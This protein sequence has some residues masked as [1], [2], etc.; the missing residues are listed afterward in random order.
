MI[1]LRI[2]PARLTRLFEE[3][4]ENWRDKVIKWWNTM[5]DLDH[6]ECGTLKT[7][8]VHKKFTLFLY[9][10]AGSGKTKFIE[11][12]LKCFLKQKQLFKISPKTKLDKF[13][14][15]SFDMEVH[16]VT[17]IDEFVEK[18]ADLSSL[19]TFCAGEMMLGEKKNRQAFEFRNDFPV[20]ISS[21]FI[22]PS[23][24]A[25]NN[26]FGE[27]L[28]I[29]CCNSNGTHQKVRPF[30]YGDSTETRHLTNVFH[31]GQHQEPE[32][33]EYAEY[34]ALKDE[35]I[36]KGLNP[37]SSFCPIRLL[38]LEE[39]DKVIQRPQSS[40]QR[41]PDAVSTF[42][43]SISSSKQLT[44]DSMEKFKYPQNTKIVSTPTISERRS[45][46]CSTMQDDCVI[47]SDDDDNDKIKKNNTSNL[48]NN[49]IPKIKLE[50]TNAASQ[51]V[52]SSQLSTRNL[53]IDTPITPEFNLT[54]FL[55][56]T[57]L[58]RL[59]QRKLTTSNTE[60]SFG[61]ISGNTSR[62]ISLIASLPLFT[63]NGMAMRR[64]P[65]KTKAAAIT[66]EI[67]ITDDETDMTQQANK[68][69]LVTLTPNGRTRDVSF[70]FS[71]ADLE[72]FNNILNDDSDIDDDLNNVF[73]K[74]SATQKVNPFPTPVTATTSKKIS[75]SKSPILIETSTAIKR[76]IGVR[77]SSPNSTPVVASRKDT[78]SP[79]SNKNS[80]ISD[81]LTKPEEGGPTQ[82][83][84]DILEYK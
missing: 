8:P 54:N 15:G 19:K 39:R 76:P 43:K 57:I 79:C 1:K 11:L 9:G 41:V 50:T 18:D 24:N 23:D 52:Q 7:K 51:Q 73:D 37:E 63:E 26:T 77:Y 42:S 29:V 25:F 62:L 3:Q 69:S 45:S 75:D 70:K 58:E 67:M 4:Q 16:R 35:A 81:T 30:Q 13:A 14:Y 44:I 12:L 64:C 82:E 59:N 53:H 80:D 5:A 72:E 40:M 21:Q 60:N 83:Q 32:T 68:R 46:F 28:F 84:I 66:Q 38:P 20:I 78:T 61:I 49:V 17:W 65:I 48:S 34:S 55:N 31:K 71:A 10:E 27:R 74:I 56:K 47:I 36:K 33:I 22:P 6:R 2:R